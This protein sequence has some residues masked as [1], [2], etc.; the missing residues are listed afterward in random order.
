MSQLSNSQDDYFND[1]ASFISDTSSTVSTV[2][3]IRE[4]AAGVITGA[5]C[6][7]D[8]PSSLT[9]ADI[10]SAALADG[11]Y[12]SYP[13][14]T[15]SPAIPTS[16]QIEATTAATMGENLAA[17]ALYEL[18]S[19]SSLPLADEDEVSKSPVYT[20]HVQT[21]PSMTAD[22][23]TGQLDCVSHSLLSDDVL[24]WTGYD[25][26]PVPCDTEALYRDLLGLINKDQG[27][28]I[29]AA[30]ERPQDKSNDCER[31]GRE[32]V[33]IPSKWSLACPTEWYSQI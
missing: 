20:Q 7:P 9:I 3:D 24:S 18:S 31:S 19:Y 16:V 21:I 10:V 13:T 15:P 23:L 14:M 2:F 1:Q 5:D 32:S 30:T 27:G 29:E 22:P 4:Q 25:T 8:V 17:E 11:G 12:I 33:H 6:M 26:E 28:H